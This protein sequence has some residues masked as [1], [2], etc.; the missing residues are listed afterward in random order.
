MSPARGPAAKHG[1]SVLVVESDADGREAFVSLLEVSGYDAKGAASITEAIAMVDRYRPDVV[2]HD[3]VF[4]LGDVRE[5]NRALRGWTDGDDP[6][7]VIYTGHAPNVANALGLKCDAFVLKP[8][9]DGLLNL[10][11]EVALSPRRRAQRSVAHGTAVAAMR[12]SRT[13]C[14]HTGGGRET[15]CLP[16]LSTTS[17]GPYAARGPESR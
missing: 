14:G 4:D 9:I 8:E 7:V 6:V 3:I 11:R 16:P 5:L 12:H 2:I 17:E 10:M 1:P 13:C 15:D